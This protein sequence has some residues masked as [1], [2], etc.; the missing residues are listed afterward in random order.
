MRADRYLFVSDLHLDASAPEGITQF[1]AF[2]DGEARVAAA[3][4]ILG[5]L[6]ETWVGD[7]DP[8]AARGTVCAALRRYTASGIPC[9]VLRGNRDFLLGAGFEQ[10]TGCKLLP[11]PVLLEHGPLRVFVSH[12][13]PLCT[14]D[15]S[16]QE[17]RSMV[18]NPEWQE[19]YLRLPLS[20]RRALA[21]AARRGSKAHTERQQEQIMDVHPEAV[22]KA[23]Q[24]SGTTLMIHGHTHRPAVHALQTDVG[25]AKRI[26]LGDWYGNGSYLALYPDG[27]YEIIALPPRDAGA[28]RPDPPSA[29]NPATAV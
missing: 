11:D 25:P 4:Y 27:Q 18:R 19:K 2:L 7:D 15:H 20:T 24:V 10:R 3:L 14:A 17:F 1:I 23:F 13:D 8:E 21:E 16:Y 22:L 29:L 26:V 6:F 5:D 9:F 28:T 12:G